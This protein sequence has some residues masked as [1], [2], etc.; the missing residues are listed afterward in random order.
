VKTWK[1]R[2]VLRTMTKRIIGFRP[3]SV[4]ARNCWRCEAPSISAASYSSRGIVCSAAR[5]R[6][7]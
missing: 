5:I 7:V 4:I 6:I 3:G 2:I 1:E